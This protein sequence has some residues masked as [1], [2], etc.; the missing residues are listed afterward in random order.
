[1]R[2]KRNIL[3]AAVSFSVAAAM[4]NMLA[5]VA[6]AAPVQSSVV[7]SLGNAFVSVTKTA[8]AS[9]S[10][11][12]LQAAVEQGLEG[13][14]SAAQPTVPEAFA[15][16]D[17]A[18]AQLKV[19]NLWTPP[20]AAAF[21]TARAAVAALLKPAAGRPGNGAGL[22]NPPSVSGGGGSQTGTYAAPPN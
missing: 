11:E 12:T 10:A 15:A 13:A 8:I 4:V 5:V 14:L 19:E 18:E 21:A 22:G 20:V 16:L 17:A 9:N 1:M 2:M 3:V 6:M 7:S